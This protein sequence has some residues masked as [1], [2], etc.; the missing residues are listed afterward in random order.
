MVH[1]VWTKND[2]ARITLRAKVGVNDIINS[3]HFEATAAQQLLNV[4]D[5][6]AQSWAQAIAADWITS[7]T[8]S[9]RACH[10]ND[11][12]LLNVV[13]QVLDRSGQLNHKLVQ[14]ENPV[15]SAGTVAGASA[16][17]SDACVTKWRSIGAGKH[18]RGRSY[19]GPIPQGYVLVGLVSATYTGLVNTYAQALL[20]R[21]SGLTPSEGALLTIYSKPLDAGKQ[22]WTKRVGP[23]LTVFSNPDYDGDSSNVVSAIVDPIIRTQR[24]REVGVGS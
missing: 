14:T 15:S 7:L 22:Q 4:S 24:K 8:A 16:A 21:Y 17:L 20:T 19:V 23:A 3:H 5:A 2:L 11:Y 18:H 12:T 9:W 13:A 1:G 6:A 10:P